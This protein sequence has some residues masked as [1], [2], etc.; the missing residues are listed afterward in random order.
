MQFFKNFVFLTKREQKHFFIQN[1]VLY[2]TGDNISGYIHEELKENN[3]LSPLEAISLVRDTLYNGLKYII[4]NCAIKTLYVVC[5][6]GNHARLTQRKS[7]STGYKNNLDYF[8]YKNLE[9]MFNT[10]GGYENIKFIIDDSELTYFNIYNYVTRCGHGD[11]FKYAGG[12]GG[13]V[14]PLMRKL[15]DWD[16][17]KKADMTI[18]GHWHT[19]IPGSEF[20]INGSIIGI[21]PFGLNFAKAGDLIPK[22]TFMLCV[23]NRGFTT[24]TPIFLD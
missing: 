15:K 3:Y 17:I 21:T 19:W 9:Q 16:S 7:F 20:L 1:V 10:I 4:D 14:V 6:F 8:C 18:F 13:L 24:R 2:V 22:Q 23:K 11:H 12:I 5:K